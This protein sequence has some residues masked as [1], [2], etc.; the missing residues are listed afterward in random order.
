[1]ERLDRESTAT[2]RDLRAALSDKAATVER[3]IAA[4]NKLAAVRDQMLRRQIV[5]L[6]N[7]RAVLTHAQWTALQQQMEGR[8]PPPRR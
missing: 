1:M 2:D 6:A 8:R 4:G 3:I 7:Q 5:M